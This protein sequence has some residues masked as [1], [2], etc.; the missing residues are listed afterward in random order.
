[1][2]LPSD[3]SQ[4]VKEEFEEY[5]RKR[6]IRPPWVKSEHET[7]YDPII[8]WEPPIEEPE[9]HTGEQ[10]SEEGE[11]RKEGEAK[12]E[13]ES[14]AG[15]KS[16]SKPQANAEKKHR[17]GESKDGEDDELREGEVVEKQCGCVSDDEAYRW[18]FLEHQR[19]GHCDIR[20]IREQ[21][22]NGEYST[23]PRLSAEQLERTQ[24]NCPV[25][26]RTRQ[27]RAPERKKARKDKKRA[28]DLRILEE[29]YVDPAGPRTVPSLRYVG[30]RGNHSGG[31]NL[32]QV[33][34]VDRK[35][36]LMVVQFVKRKSEIEEAVKL[37]RAEL[38][39]A[40]LNSIEYQGQPIRIGKFISDGDSNLTSDKAVAEMLEERT[41]H[42]MTAADQKNGT[43]LLDR[44][45]RHVLAIVRSV[46]DDSG[47]GEEYWEF[48]T[49]VRSEADERAA[50]QKPRVAS[51]GD[52][53][54]E[55]VA[56]GFECA[57]NV[58]CG[59]LPVQGAVGTDQ[60]VKAGP[61]RTWRKGSVPICR[62]QRGRRIRIDG[63]ESPRY[64][65]QTSTNTRPQKLQAQRGHG[66]SARIASSQESAS[67]RQHGPRGRASERERVK[68]DGS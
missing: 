51:L 46:L 22:R 50:I 37:A 31:G 18:L 32:Y 58:W 53:A 16:K 19:R 28:K 39:I 17:K 65:C 3:C 36:N 21:Y 20:L 59:R 45:I 60:Q 2:Q 40:A 1:M 5:W 64:V 57:A 67:E 29:V 49:R 44:M 30:E 7:Y 43:P 62:S 56:T 14:S 66:A 15:E 33:F 63:R 9:V 61:D 48:A 10:A 25:C 26:H 27:T 8:V 23:A 4:E 52:S 12:S 38:E 42:L 54:L 41:F 35:T 55:G 68:G 47:L 11:K 6:G 24:L 34:F 13:T